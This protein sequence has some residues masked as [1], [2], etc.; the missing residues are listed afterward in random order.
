MADGLLTEQEVADWLA[1]TPITLRKWRM[2]GKG[3]RFL[4][5]P[6]G[7]VRYEHADVVAWVGAREA[8]GS[9]TG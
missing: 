1:L 9:P 8:S 4:K 6:T 5:L 2:E 3:P 7:T